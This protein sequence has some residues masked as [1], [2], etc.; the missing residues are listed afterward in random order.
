MHTQKDSQDH[1]ERGGL[2]K[3]L[4][5]EVGRAGELLVQYRLMKGGISSGQLT[6][7]CGVDV[8]AYHRQAQ[9]P[10]TIQVKTSRP[11]C[12]YERTKLNWCV[13]RECPAHYVA[14]VDL[15]GDRVWL[16]D[17]ASFMQRAQQQRDG[18][19]SLWAYIHEGGR[20]VEDKL[21]GLEIE[22][23]IPRIFVTCGGGGY[24]FSLYP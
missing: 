5:V 7:D 17:Y 18:E 9:R 12:R 21:G 1:Q 15:E 2:E 16:M 4:P 11:Q 14:L 24:Y 10:I 3:L 13:R 19:A 8:V 6:I 22:A 20:G 23:A